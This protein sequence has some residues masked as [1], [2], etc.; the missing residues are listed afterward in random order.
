MATTDC[1]SIKPDDNQNASSLASILGALGLSSCAEA[2]GSI[3]T[4]FGSAATG[5]SIGCEQVAVLQNQMSSAQANIT[6]ILNE[7]KNNNTLTMTQENNVTL[8]IQGVNISEINISQTND[9]TA[10]SFSQLSNEDT[11]NITQSLK[12]SLSSAIADSQNSKTES[13]SVPDGQKAIAQSLSDLKEYEIDN[14]ASKAIQDTMA[15][16]KQG[17]DIVINLTGSDYLSVAMLQ[18]ENPLKDLNISQDNMIKYTASQ[19]VSSFVSNVISQAG[20]ADVVSQLSADQVAVSSVP[21]Y[22]LGAIGLIVVVVLFFLVFKGGSGMN[23]VTK[24]IIPGIFVVAVVLAIV[25]G[26]LKNTIAT[27]I[28]SGVALICGVLTYFSIKR[29]L[30]KPPVPLDLSKTK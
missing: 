8:N 20:T 5:A 9:V 19:I 22:S 17:N 30:I 11:A 12:T 4:P 23:K 16:L 6:C 7:T 27:L 14:A 21:Q 25:F 1:A 18:G 10:W 28:C 24:F 26:K 29:S 3:V 13:G 2:S 15:K